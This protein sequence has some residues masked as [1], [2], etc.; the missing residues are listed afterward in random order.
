MPE[1]VPHQESVYAALLTAAAGVF[2]TAL[3][4]LVGWLHDKGADARRTSA[5]KQLLDRVQLLQAW[6]FTR[7]WVSP[8]DVESCRSVVKQELDLAMEAVKRLGI[9]AVEPGVAA[10]SNQAA[11]KYNW[12]RRWF[13]L[14]KPSAFF[15]WLPRLF[16]YFCLW[17]VA[18]EVSDLFSVVMFHPRFFL[19][20]ALLRHMTS[21]AVFFITFLGARWFAVWVDKS[22]ST[23]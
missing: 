20:D 17:M 8:D 23:Q 4:L 21:L 19:K 1:P 10:Q 15:A 9:P 16:F 12:F 2:T 7:T 22:E 5:T 18:L 14:Y 3:T 13:L 6:Y 11:T